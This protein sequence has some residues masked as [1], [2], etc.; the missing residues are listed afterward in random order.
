VN[1]VLFLLGLLNRNASE[2][3]AKNSN[4]LNPIFRGFLEKY[5]TFGNNHVGRLSCISASKDLHNG[6]P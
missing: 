1:L 3:Y 6:K 4:I 5:I 2:S